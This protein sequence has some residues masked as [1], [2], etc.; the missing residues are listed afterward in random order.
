[1]SRQQTQGEDSKMTKILQ[2]PIWKILGSFNSTKMCLRE[3]KRSTDIIIKKQISEISLRG[4][5]KT[6]I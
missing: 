4:D 5:H 3:K 2:C 1:M 6:D